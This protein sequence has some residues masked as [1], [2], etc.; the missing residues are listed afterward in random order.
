MAQVFIY[1]SEQDAINAVATL[2]TYY[3]IPKG[4]ESVTQTLCE[5]NTWNDKYIIHYD[6]CMLV[7][8]G[9]PLEIDL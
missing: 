6:D 4:A 1:N 3:G 7:V 5:Y 9:V 8:F 2:N